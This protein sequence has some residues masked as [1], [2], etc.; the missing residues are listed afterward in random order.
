MADPISSTALMAQGID[1]AI[2]HIAD[3]GKVAAEQYGQY[4]IEELKQEVE[5]L[6]LQSSAIDMGY[7][8]EIA[9]VLYKILH[10]MGGEDDELEEK[11]FHVAKS[12]INAA[13]FLG[14]LLDVYAHLTTKFKLETAYMI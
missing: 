1:K 12:C 7:M 10:P 3:V 14:A 2:G 11:L 4:K 8:K 9:S 6:K 5:K 13:D